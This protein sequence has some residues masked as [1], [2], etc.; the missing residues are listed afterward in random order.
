MDKDFLEKEFDI[1]IKNG[2]FNK[3][4]AQKYINNPSIIEAVELSTSPKKENIF[5]ALK[6]VSYQNLKVLI[7]GQDP[8]PNPNHAHGLAFSSK[9]I[10][11]PQSL[12]NIFKVI[13]KTYNLNLFDKKINDLT[14]WAKQG[15]LL[16]NTSLTFQKFED[17]KQQEK[18]QK[19][20]LKIWKP[21]ILDVIKKILSV[22]SSPVCLMLWGNSAHDLVFSAVKSKEDKKFLHSRNPIILSQSSVMLLQCSHPSPLSVN[23]GGD[24]L[25]IAGGHF[26]ECEKYLKKDKINW[27]LL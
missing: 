23:R 24:F 3:N 16:L 17:K 12:Q 11:S 20:N 13:D 10:Q 27:D 6:L 19:N 15:V 21:F 22:N 9:D 18:S 2:W 5:N 7:L 4:E 25:Q 1:L 8:Y 26:K 14:N